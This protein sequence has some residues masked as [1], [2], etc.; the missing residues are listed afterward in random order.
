MRPREEPPEVIAYLEEGK[1]GHDA[2]GT[3]TWIQPKITPRAGYTDHHPPFHG[4]LN[5]RSWRGRDCCDG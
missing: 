3:P 1:E 5:M 4:R 2:P